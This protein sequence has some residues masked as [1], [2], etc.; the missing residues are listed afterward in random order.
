MFYV[1]TSFIFFKSVGMA[2]V[3]KGEGVGKR[4]WV[5]DIGGEEISLSVYGDMFVSPSFFC[6]SICLSVSL[7]LS[8]PLLFFCFNLEA[9]PGRR[10]ERFAY[11]TLFLQRHTR[12]LLLFRQRVEVK[13]A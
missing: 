4:Y 9:Y 13:C 1:E 2:G 5:V 7:S 10:V 12:C 11:A 6:P 8:F 3:D